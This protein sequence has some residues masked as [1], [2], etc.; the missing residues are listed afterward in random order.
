PLEETLRALDDLIHMGK[1]RYIGASNIPAWLMTKSLWLSDKYHLYRFDWVQN[2][3]SLLD[4]ADEREMFPLCADQKIGY[5]PFSPLAGGLLTGKYQ[6]DRDYPSGSRMTLRPEPYLRYWNQKT[7][8]G[9]E[10]F[11]TEA[12]RRGIS[13]SG[14][15]LAW[16][17]SSPF[18]T[19]PIIGPR[20]LDHFEPVREALNVKLTAEKREALAKLLAD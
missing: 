9:L 20:K 19:A 7:F 3:Y 15:A 18:V 5:T 1:L 10:R 6:L 14:L 16:V 4:R 2:S 17:M 8:D 12:Q 13:P 11:K